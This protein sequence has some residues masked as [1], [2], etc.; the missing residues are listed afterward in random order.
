MR[1]YLCVVFALSAFACGMVRPE[2]GTVAG[3]VRGVKHY[4]STKL[5]PPLADREITL[6]D[7]DDGTIAARTRTDSEGKFTFTVQPGKYSIWGGE[8]AEYAR[9]KSGETSTVEITAPEKWAHSA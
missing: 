9:V 6:M 7:S 5:G 2:P 1:R 4:D 3:V 8:H